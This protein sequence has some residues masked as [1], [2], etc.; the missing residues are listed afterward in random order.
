M[1]KQLSLNRSRVAHKPAGLADIVGRWVTFSLGHYTQ[2]PLQRLLG[3]IGWLTRLAFPLDVSSRVHAHGFVWV[4]LL[5]VASRLPRV[6]ASWRRS[7][8]GAGGASRR[9]LKDQRS[10]YTLTLRNAPSRQVVFLWGY[11]APRFLRSAGAPHGLLPS[12]PLS[13]MVLCVLLMWLGALGAGT[14]TLS[15][16]TWAR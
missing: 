12:N 14:W 10:G 13:Y 3:R 6:G 1:E 16:T 11:G 4:R 8:P 5:P 15:W 2:K 7:R 9:R